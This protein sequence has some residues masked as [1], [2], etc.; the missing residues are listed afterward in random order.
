M[1]DG[2]QISS[3]APPAATI[4]QVSA[5]A[6]GAWRATAVLTLL[7]WF[8]TLDRQVAALLIPLIKAD[9]Q[10]TDLQISMI[11]GLA[12]GLFFMLMSPV[13]GWLV[14]RYSRRM[15]LFVGVVGWSVSAVCSG[16]TRSFWGLFAARAG[17]GG[18]EA[19]IN[20]TAYAMLS[21]LYPPSK[22]SLPL[23][24]F[25]MGGNLGSGMSFLLGGAVI[26]WVAAS[27]PLVLP[28]VGTLAGWQIAF[29]ITGLPGLLLAPLLFTIP[30]SRQHLDRQSQPAT[31]TTFADLFRHYR[32]FPFFYFAHGLGFALIMAFVVGLQSWNAT[33]LSRHHAWELSTIGYWMGLCQVGSALLGL[34]VHGWA[35][36]KLF[37]S[38]R[39]DAH[40][41]YFAVMCVL[42]F[43]FAI[44]AYVVDSGAAM[45]ALYSVAY[46][47]IMA[48]ASVGPAAL[49]IATP[50]KLRGKASSVYM[51]GVSIIG[52]ILGP[53]VVATFTDKLFGDEAAL[54]SSMALFA[55]LTT[56]VAAILF[57]AGRPAMRR[58]IDSAMAP[59][60]QL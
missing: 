10:L 43:P 51:V 52:T 8:G 49:Q 55:G 35:V 53:I 16:L 25:V 22:L 37:S 17:V 45:L 9:M 42:A 14:D 27:P 34:A 15:I 39:R 3:E 40:L 5:V 11:Q 18:C 6:D 12:F 41:T 58:A 50:V 19:S 30:E 31:N 54:G 47:C 2:A 57:I 56:G 36:D 60:K 26:A 29:V 24:L 44:A 1:A 13:M 32:R 7:Y 48:F 4:G 21:E 38:G 23:S 33:F 46:F 20:P 59:S 28:F